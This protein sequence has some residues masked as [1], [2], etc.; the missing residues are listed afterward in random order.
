MVEEVSF[1]LK[2]TKKMLITTLVAV[3]LF[4]GVQP[5][6]AEAFIPVV[7]GGLAL[8]EALFIAAGIGAVGYGLYETYGGDTVTTQVTDWAWNGLKL[9]WNKL[10]NKQAWAEVEANIVSGVDT[11]VTLTTTM[12]DQAVKAGL[13]G[14]QIDRTAIVPAIPLPSDR[15]TYNEV[16]QDFMVHYALL[17]FSMNGEQFAL[18]P[19]DIAKGSSITYQ[20]FHWNE[21][22]LKWV[23]G[24]RP[25]AASAFVQTQFTIYSNVSQKGLY[26][27][28]WSGN[29]PSE[30]TYGAEGW[31]GTMIT[32]LD[33]VPVIHGILQSTYG[34][35]SVAIPTGWAD[36]GLALP[37]PQEK[38]LSKPKAIPIPPGAISYP[39]TGEATLTLTA[40][41][42]KE[43]IGEMVGE[44]DVPIEGGEN[45]PKENW[46]DRLSVAIS[47]RFPFSIPWDIRHIISVFVRKPEV[48]VINVK[49]GPIKFK[50]VL[51]Q[52]DSYMPFFRILLLA[53]FL[54]SLALGTRKILGSGQ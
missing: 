35:L 50:I 54:W 9:A 29:V 26:S 38:D 41:Q 17:N 45:P 36:T 6:K 20:W 10:T 30:L 15:A 42:I 43:M 3:I 4:T 18:M 46:P 53:G 48:P 5:K 31:P 16:D 14:W 28:F 51:D 47:T 19:Y 39:T 52:L 13:L 24:E 25:A 49:A 44:V 32:L 8:G 23:R 2:I 33:I 12:W 21:D 7:I 11:A 22:K 37:I 27:V 34:G 40:E 1:I